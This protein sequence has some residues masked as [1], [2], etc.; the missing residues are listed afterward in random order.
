MSLNKKINAKKIAKTGVRTAGS[1]ISLIFKTIGTLVLIAVTTGLIFACIFTV[2]IQ[3]NLTTELGV[4]LEEFGKSESS[5]I[6]YKDTSTDEYKKLV[7]IQSTQYRIWVDYDDIPKYAEHALVAIEDKRFYDHSGVDWYRTVAAFGNMFLR[8]KDNF[9]GSTITQQLIKTLTQEDEVTVQ[10]KLLEIFRA[11]EFQKS[12]TREEIIEGYLNVVTFGGN[13][14]GLGA[15]ADYY[16]GKTASEL[17]LAEC[18]CIIGITNN[19]SMYN[20]YIDKEANKERQELILTNMREQGYITTDAELDEAIN[21]KLIFQKGENNTNSNEIY[22]W[23][24]DAVIEDVITDLAEL[25]GVTRQAAETLLFTGGYQIRCCMDQTIQAQVDSIY[26][27]LEAIPKVGGSSQPLASAIVLANPYTGEILAMEGNVGEKTASRMFNRAT[28]SHRPPGSSIKPLSVYAPAIEFRVI[29]PETRFEDSADV[30]LEGTDWMPKNDDWSYSGILNIRTAVIRSKNTIAAQVIDQLSPKRSY[31]FMV[32]TLGIELSP[33]DEDYAPLALGQLTNGITVREMAS[34]YTMFDNGGVEN[35]L[36][37]YTKVLMSDGETVV[38][39]NQPETSIAISAATA[40]W[41][42]SMLRDAATYGTGSEANLGDLMPVAGKTGTT[43]DKKDRWFAGFTPYYVAVVWTGFDTPA[44]MKVTGNPAAQLWKK[45]MKL[46]HEGYEWKDFT[47]PPDTYLSPIPGV[48][49][50]VS[51]VVRGV[52][53][54]DDSELYR[55]D[56]KTAIKGKNITEIANLIEGYE[57][58]GETEKTKTITDDPKNNIFE[59]YYQMIAPSPSPSLDPWVSPPID[60]SSDVS[61]EPTA[62][63]ESPPVTESPSPLPTDATS[64]SPTP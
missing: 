38:I 39:D 26:Q 17:T 2:Y 36:I 15:A 18:A 57:I 64:P 29:T 3:T 28:Q 53:I 8:M 45:V 59:F 6:Y 49:E 58:V 48:D 33:F 55:I 47:T 34:A 16:F 19:P 10:R 25:K 43:T 50:P 24:E 60:P 46:V 13:C 35:R 5:A 62:P 41:V 30:R 52:N 27:D 44:T 61:A 54:E 31:D 7:T 63:T 42:T 14:Y 9:G 4:S 40:Y 1:V 51:Y 22:T 12:Y 23:Y 37:T 20:P 32:D 56:D 11:L 21:Q